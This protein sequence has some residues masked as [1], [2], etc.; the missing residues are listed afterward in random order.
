MIARRIALEPE[1]GAGNK[2]K[3]DGRK[4]WA[5]RTEQMR[6]LIEVTAAGRTV[7]L[8][9][10]LALP[11]LGSPSRLIKGGPIIGEICTSMRIPIDMHTN[12]VFLGASVT[13]ANGLG[14]VGHKVTAE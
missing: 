2:T 4:I 10:G 7:V 5:F 12:L 8:I 11:L 6:K 9:P 14:S 1:Q 3:Q 13:T